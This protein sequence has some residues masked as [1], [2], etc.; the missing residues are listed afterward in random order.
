LERAELPEDAH[1][2]ELRELDA[3]RARA[4]Y[5]SA[6]AALLPRF[7]APQKLLLG[8]TGKAS[9][10]ILREF[11]EKFHLPVSVASLPLEMG[12]D[13]KQKVKTF[14]QSLSQQYEKG[15]DFIFWMGSVGERLRLI[16]PAQDATNFGASDVVLAQ[17]LMKRWIKSWHLVNGWLMPETKWRS[18]QAFSTDPAPV[19]TG[20]NSSMA[21]LAQKCGFAK[22]YGFD[23]NG[24]ITVSEWMNYH[25]ALMA[26]AHILPLVAGKK[27]HKCASAAQNLST[28]HHLLPCPDEAK[29]Q[30]MR[31]LIESFDDHECEVNDGVKI[32]GTS[33][34]VV[35]RLCAGRPALEV[36]KFSW[37][38]EGKIEE[39]LE[40]LQARVLWNLNEWTAEIVREADKIRV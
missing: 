34:W 40:A 5:L 14:Q 12:A 17:L 19:V 26:L 16:L 33:G 29:A 30:V 6:M 11:F 31:R 8:V 15:Y 3:V 28:Q 23:G 9:E 39:D 1:A 20:M 25:D 2:G 10:I 4:D 38:K 24:G 13:F 35:V 7:T 37:R 36:F 18:P 32:K 27:V 21:K 22:W